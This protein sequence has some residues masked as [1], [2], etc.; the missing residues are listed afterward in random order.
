MG[1]TANVTTPFN[2][3]NR[4]REATTDDKVVEHNPAE[5]EVT[6]L[7]QQLRQVPA[8]VVD[9]GLGVALAVAITI[10]IR[11]APGPDKQPDAVAYALELTIAALTLARRRWLLASAA[12]LQV[13]YLSAYTS[14]Y[15]AVPLSVALATPGPPATAAGRC[16]SPP[17]TFWGR[18][19]TPSSSCR[20]RPDNR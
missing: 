11:V 6:C 15:P 12:T 18:S 20:H 7:W 14:T 17:S 4:R 19:A 3:L 2:R 8:P 13:S 1:S 16:W 5:L 10:G 9:A